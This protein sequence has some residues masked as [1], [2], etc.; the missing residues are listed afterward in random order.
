VEQAKAAVAG[1]ALGPG[2]FIAYTARRAQIETLLAEYRAKAG[3]GASL[4]DFHDRLL[5]Y[6][7]TPL[8]IIGPELLADLAKP[9]ADVRASAAY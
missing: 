5:C 2:Y 7:S 8:S 6:G 4:R 1:I 9:L 3:A